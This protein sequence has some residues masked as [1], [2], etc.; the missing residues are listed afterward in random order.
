LWRQGKIEHTSP[1]STK[2]VLSEDHLYTIY[3]EDGSL[4]L[5]GETKVFQDIDNDASEALRWLADRDW[6]EMPDATAEPF[7]RFIHTL[8]PRSQRMR[9]DFLKKDERMQADVIGELRR[10]GVPNAEVVGRMSAG[11]AR[12]RAVMRMLMI[13]KFDDSWRK[14]FNGIPSYVYDISAY[15]AEF[16]TSDYP[17]SS[18]PAIDAPG[19]VHVFPVSPSRC[20]VASHDPAAVE[21]LC[22]MPPA[23]FTSVVNLRTLA[24]AHRA[25]ARDKRYR[26]QIFK[27]L[28]C[29]VNPEYLKEALRGAFAG[30]VRTG[31]GPDVPAEWRHEDPDPSG[32]RTRKEAF[33]AG[34]DGVLWTQATKEPVLHTVGPCEALIWTVRDWSL[35]VSSY[36]EAYQLG[37][38]LSYIFFQLD[39]WGQSKDVGE[40]M[41]KRLRHE[42]VRSVTQQRRTGQNAVYDLDTLLRTFAEITQVSLSQIYP[43]IEDHAREVWL[44]VNRGFPLVSA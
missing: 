33:C 34:M 17:L 31:V 36:R 9:D 39:R 6:R 14:F 4:V 35:Q 28:G 25:I 21:R 40:E 30:S 16:F 13:A 12:D 10:L 19:A 24:G 29:D 44:Y 5:H 23:I 20:W 42:A 41:L 11:S 8:A 43:N 32:Y 27:Y 38:G 2:R 15:D 3:G 22:G 7:Y 37:R 26:E 1:C 18:T